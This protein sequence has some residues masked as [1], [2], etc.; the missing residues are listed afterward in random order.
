MDVEEST[1]K[2]N[3]NVWMTRWRNTGMNG[4]KES[5][6]TLVRS[7]VFVRLSDLK[8]AQIEIIVLNVLLLFNKIVIIYL[9]NF[10]MFKKTKYLNYHNKKLSYTKITMEYHEI[11]YFSSIIITI[12]T[13]R[14]LFTSPLFTPIERFNV[15]DYFWTMKPL[16]TTFFK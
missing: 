3:D 6:R 13:M 1:P 9:S 7:E 10:L 14:S 16:N 8:L 5:R 11:S 4:R 12:S 15:P 2:S